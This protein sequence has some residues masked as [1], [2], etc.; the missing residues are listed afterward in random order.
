MA[1]NA[2]RPDSIREKASTIPDRQEG[3]EATLEDIWLSL[4]WVEVVLQDNARLTWLAVDRLELL[5]VD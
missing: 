4:T 5:L 2:I 3:P 1:R